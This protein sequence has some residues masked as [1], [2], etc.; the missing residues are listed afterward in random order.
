M[1]K[2][3]RTQPQTLDQ[4][5]QILQSMPDYLLP[6]GTREWI[7]QA[8]NVATPATSGNWVLFFKSGGLFLRD[9]AGTVTGPLV[10][11]AGSGGLTSAYVDMT[12]GTITASASGA[13]TFKFRTGNGILTIVV[14]S[15]DVTHGD[16]A[17]FTIDESVIDHG[18]I[19]GLSDDDHS[20][21]HNDDRGDVRYFR[22]L[23][24][25]T[26]DDTV[27]NTTTQTLFAP[28]GSGSP[29]LAGNSLAV[30]DVLEIRASGILSTV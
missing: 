25:S 21:Y 22:G 23:F 1:N 24:S 12:D 30:G 11:A 5:R 28:S 10:D 18:S 7:E 3:F 27:A 29:A 2:D 9:D 19:A 13:D 15:N 4:V 16:N 17:L 14:T 26:A 8:A 6:N 20:Q